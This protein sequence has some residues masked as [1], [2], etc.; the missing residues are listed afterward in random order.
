[1]TNTQSSLASTPFTSLAPP[2]IGH[3]PPQELI[4]KNE[5][6]VLIDHA[7]SKRKNVSQSPIWEHGHDYVHAANSDTHA[8]RCSYCKK[9]ILSSALTPH[10]T[11]G[12]ISKEC[13]ASTVIV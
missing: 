9:I 4:F 2:P 12:S 1:M 7:P 5:R 3:G 11:L 8:W 10:R 6:W 13:I